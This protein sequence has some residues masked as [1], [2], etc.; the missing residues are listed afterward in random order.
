M[1]FNGKILQSVSNYRDGP[2]DNC[3]LPVFP[4]LSLARLPV[5][6][7]LFP[8]DQFYTRL[9]GLGIPQRI[10]AL[11]LFSFTAPHWPRLAPNKQPMGTALSDGAGSDSGA[12]PRGS[13]AKESSGPHPEA[14]Q[15]KREGECVREGRRVGQKVQQ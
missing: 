10:A 1:E 15:S 14:P 6:S 2:V 12:R 8:P 7:R 13:E 5:N 4:W 9:A 11:F 3:R